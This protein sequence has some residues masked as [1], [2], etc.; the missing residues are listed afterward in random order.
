MV[1]EAMGLDRI[2]EYREESWQRGLEEF[3][4][5]SMVLCKEG[6]MGFGIRNT[7][8]VSSGF[9]II[10][11]FVSSPLISPWK[12]IFFLLTFFRVSISAQIPHLHMYVVCLF[13]EIFQ[14]LNHSDFYFYMPV[15]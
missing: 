3:Q 12:E 5:K 7:G 8:R 14:Y 9:L 15:S 4:G 1:H 6:N 13:H 10:S 2:L 11:F